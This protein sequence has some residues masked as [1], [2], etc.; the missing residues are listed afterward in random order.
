MKLNNA[1]QDGGLVIGAINRSS[2]EA[3]EVFRQSNLP[4]Q[5]TE[6][7]LIVHQTGLPSIQLRY[8]T[9]DELM[10]DLKNRR[11]DLDEDAWER[12]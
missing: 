6:Y 9:L 10:D 4:I 8:S 1:L 2:G 11:P 5:Q 12:T 3:V 7:R